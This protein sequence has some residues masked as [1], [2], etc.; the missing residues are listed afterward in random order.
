MNGPNTQECCITLV[1]KGLPLTSTLAY[2]AHSKVT[3]KIKCC[4]YGSR[5]SVQ[6]RK[7]RQRYHILNASFSVHFMNGPITQECYI[8]LGRKGLPLT[9]TLAY[10]AHSK[11]AKKIKFCYYGSRISVQK[12]KLRQRYSQCFIFCA[13]YEWG[14]YP[15]VLHYTWPKRLALDK[16]FGLLCPFESYKEYIV[17]SIWLQESYSK[18][19]IFFEA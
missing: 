10:C 11:V 8:I 13:F 3:K 4:Y 2:C 15:R 19:F 5:I 17:L 1:W 18:H 6:K 14:H 7:L 12:R 16:P 9:S